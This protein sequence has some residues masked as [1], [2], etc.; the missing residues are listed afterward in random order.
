MCKITPNQLPDGLQVGTPIY[1]NLDVEFVKS[2]HSSR[3]IPVDITLAETIHG[4]RL[5]IGPHSRDFDYEKEPAKNA[6]R[7][8]QTIREQLAKLGDT[9]YEARNIDIALSQPYFIPISIL[10]LWRRETL[11]PSH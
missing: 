2:L 7:A 9:I 4:F 11:Q 6:E 8:L 5:T 1:R 3:R 10:N